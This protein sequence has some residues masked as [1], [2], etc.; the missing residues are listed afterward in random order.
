M[1]PHDKSTREHWQNL[2]QRA[3]HFLHGLV[4]INPAKRMTA[5][6]ALDHPWFTQPGTEAKLL[7]EGYQRVIRF[8]RK[9]DDYEQVMEDLP[10]RTTFSYPDKNP[11]GPKPWR[12]IPDVSSS[13]YFG[14][15]RHLNQNHNQKLASKR[16][17]ILEEVNNSGARFLMSDTSRKTASTKASFRQS[18]QPIESVDGR[19]I[20]GTSSSIQKERSEEPDPD[21]VSLV[22]TTPIPHAE[23]N[24][25]FDLSDAV[26]PNSQQK[27]LSMRPR[28]A[29]ARKRVRIESEN[30]EERSLRE[31]VAKALP[32][33]SSA[34]VLKDELMKKRLE[35]ELA[36]LRVRHTSKQAI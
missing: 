30:E 13:P 3:L 11:P 8:W 32:K 25:G 22:P 23:R 10:G 28:A 17:N 14:L 33:Y 21:E 35:K 4:I 6:Q 20:F 12:R 36:D 9:R 16:K 7:V 31:E 34:K 27:L 24:Y 26:I 2:S 1:G 5:D 18:K 29:S 15:E 19:D